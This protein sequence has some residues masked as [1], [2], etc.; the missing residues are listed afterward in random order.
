MLAW[1][2]ATA[3]VLACWGAP[4]QHNQLPRWLAIDQHSRR[5]RRMLA[6]LCCWHEPQHTNTP[7]R[8]WHTG[9]LAYLSMASQRGRGARMLACLC[10]WHAPQHATSTLVVGMLACWH[11]GI[12]IDGQPARRGAKN[13][14]LSVL[15]ACTRACQHPGCWHAGMLECTPAAQTDHHASTQHAYVH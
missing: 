9:M 6:C 3:R 15:L 5:G 1:Q 2:P 4:N 12:P 11:A 14:G 10:C 7:A 13:A 8:C